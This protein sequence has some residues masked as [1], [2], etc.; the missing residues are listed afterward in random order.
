MATA[1]ILSDK[2]IRAAIK[3]ATT[4]GKPQ[5]LRDGDGMYLEARPN[6]VGWWRLRFRNDG[7]EGLISLG[8]Y[9]HIPLAEAR[10][11]RDAARRNHATGSSPGEQRRTEKATKT[12][13]AEAARLEAAGL[14][15]PGTFENVA[16]LWLSTVHEARVSAGHAE[17][18]RIRLEQMVFPYL[19]QRQIA[20]IEAPELL[21]VLRKI[22]E[23]GT[24]ETTHRTKDACGQVF[25]FG[26]AS[27]ACTRNPAADL[28]DALRPVPSRHFAAI[29]EPTAAGELLRA[30]AAYHGHPV[31]VA[32]LKLSDLTWNNWSSLMFPKIEE[33][34]VKDHAKTTVYDGSDYSQ[35]AR[36]RRPVRSRQD[37][38]RG[39][40]AVRGHR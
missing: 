15:G 28:R 10:V 19:G 22:E 40:Q 24:L 11:R 27:G 4:T 29:V 9:P 1:N 5:R 20:E 6:G 8:V 25:R 37:D 23:R 16:R 14:P 17:R 31:T 34:R 26:I 2:T 7:K 12:A 38:S 33:R 3:A 39:L 13:K 21:A 36:G 35:A 18:T 30:I 32:A